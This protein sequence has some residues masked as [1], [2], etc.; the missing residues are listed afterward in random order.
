MTLALASMLPATVAAAPVLPAP[1]RDP[2][3]AWVP[4]ETGPEH[5]LAVREVGYSFL[6]QVYAVPGIVAE[7]PEADRARAH[8]RFV[9][10]ALNVEHWEAVDRY[11]DELGEAIVRDALRLVC[12]ASQQAAAGTLAV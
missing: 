4:S 11:G 6:R 10:Y 1:T 9:A 2:F 3:A 12:W 8:D 5:G 7:L